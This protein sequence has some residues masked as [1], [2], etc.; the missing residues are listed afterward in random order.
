MNKDKIKSKLDVKLVINIFDVKP[1]QEVKNTLRKLNNQENIIIN[2]KLNFIR[3]EYIEFDFREYKSFK[4]FFKEIYYRN[5]SIDRA[6]DIQKEFNNEHIALERCH[7][8]LHPSVRPKINEEF[9]IFETWTKRAVMKKL[10][11]NRGV[12]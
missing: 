1:F 3:N 6:E 7:S 9:L 11:G 4:E 8:F 10:F 2:K 12:S 5:I